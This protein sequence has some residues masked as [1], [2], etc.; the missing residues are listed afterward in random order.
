MSKQLLI[1]RHAKS[2]YANGGLTDYERPLNKR[3]LRVAPQIAE[4]I[5]LQ[6]L[7]PDAI[8]SSSAKRA[9]MTA[10][11]FVP[12]CKGVEESQLSFS[13]A[14]Y[15][16]PSSVYLKFLEKFSIDTVNTLMFV[17]H[18]P[19]LEDLVEK[20]G[21]QWEIMPTAAVA[22]FDLGVESWKDVTI[23]IKG[24]LKNLWRPKEIPIQ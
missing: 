19:G 5:H 11:L 16:A 1:M 20:I 17:G 2:S 21:G 24:E 12:H 22:H 6:G 3:G 15:H 4:F 9:E 7:T 8:V 18:N 14:F 10:N 23:P 13:K